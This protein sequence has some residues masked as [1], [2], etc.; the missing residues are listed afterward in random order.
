MLFKSCKEKGQESEEFDQ[1]NN[2]IRGA[3]TARNVG[4]LRLSRVASA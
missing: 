4:S 2:Q 3:D 1:D